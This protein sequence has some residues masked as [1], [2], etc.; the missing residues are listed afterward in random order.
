MQAQEDRYRQAE[1]RR[2][3]DAVRRVQ[4]ARVRVAATRFSFLRASGPG[5]VH[6]A[7]VALLRECA[8]STGESMKKSKLL[9]LKTI[10]LLILLIGI[11]PTLWLKE[12]GCLIVLIGLFPTLWIYHKHEK[13]INTDVILPWVYTTIGG[14]VMFI[15]GGF[16]T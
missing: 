10:G 15:I 8:G 12:I 3:G 9:W 4:P 6:S 5:K 7:D 14:F 16:L 2:Q 11:I 13:P 1:G